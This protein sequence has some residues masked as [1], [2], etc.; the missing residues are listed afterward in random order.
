MNSIPTPNDFV[1]I[2]ELLPEPNG[3]KRYMV[4]ISYQD[5]NGRCIDLRLLPLPI[6]GRITLDE[7][8]EVA[9][10][11]K[12]HLS[13]YYDIVSSAWDCSRDFRSLD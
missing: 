6:T 13:D 4:R 3:D 5:K 10:L 12:S 9:R 7:A 11:A 1:H 8:E 2:E